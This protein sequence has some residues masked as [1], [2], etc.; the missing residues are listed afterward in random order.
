MLPTIHIMVASQQ[1][2]RANQPVKQLQRPLKETQGMADV[3]SD[4]EA[5]RL[6]RLDS[7]RECQIRLALR[8]PVME[9]CGDDNAHKKGFQAKSDI[10]EKPDFF[11]KVGLLDCETRQPADVQ[12]FRRS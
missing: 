3:A 5:I 12:L 2:P 6:L 8:W 1:Q 10:W 11:G 9:V 7:A 4:D